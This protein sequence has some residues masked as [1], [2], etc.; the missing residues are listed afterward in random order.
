[1]LTIV[2][3]CGIVEAVGDDVTLFKVGDKVA[4]VFPQGHHY[5]S[6]M[7]LTTK[8]GAWRLGAVDMTTPLNPR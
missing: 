5:V 3:G 8:L 4:P 2:D 7:A 1:V 6:D